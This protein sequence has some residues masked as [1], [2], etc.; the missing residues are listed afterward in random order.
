MLYWIYFIILSNIIILFVFFK[1][2]EVDLVFYI[3]EKLLKSFYW[4][5]KCFIWEI[6]M[7]FLLIEIIIVWKC[8]L[9]M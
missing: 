9:K 3:F 7:S 2:M 4:K 6:I 8:F 1:I 5:Y